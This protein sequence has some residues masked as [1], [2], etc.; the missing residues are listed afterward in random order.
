MHD[1]FKS[2]GSAVLAPNSDTQP[3]ILLIDDDDAFNSMLRDFLNVRAGITIVSVN[4]GTD[5]WKTLRES[6]FSLVIL[7]WKIPGV[8]GFT[9]FNRLRTL[10]EYEKTP[11]MVSSGL[12]QQADFRLHEEYPCTLSLAKPYS[13]KEFND[14]INRLLADRKWYANH[15]DQL[16]K[17]MDGVLQKEKSAFDE[18]Q[19]LLQKSSANTLPLSI[20][21]ARQA[22]KAKD[23]KTAE[24]LLRSVLK[25][26]PDSV[27]AMFELAKVLLENERLLEAMTLLTAAQSLSPKNL[28]RAYIMGELSLNQCQPKAAESYFDAALQIDPEHQPSQRGKSLSSALQQQPTIDLTTGKTCQS[29]AAM[30]NILGIALVRSGNYEAGIKR[31]EE[32]LDFVRNSTDQARL[33]Y[34]LGLGLT[35]AGRPHDAKKWY[36]ESLRLSGGTLVKARTALNGLA[37]DNHDFTKTEVY[38]NE[39]APIKASAKANEELMFE[40]ED[41][42][43]ADV[44]IKAEAATKAKAVA[45]AAT[46]AKAEAEAAAKAKAVAEAATKAKAE[47]EAAAKAKAKAVAEAATKAKA[48]TEAAAKAKA[49]AKP[50]AKAIAKPKFLPPPA[51]ETL[52]LPEQT[53][54]VPATIDLIKMALDELSKRQATLAKSSSPLGKAS[55][56]LYHDQDQAWTRAEK[57]LHLLGAQSTFGSY[58]IQPLLDAIRVAPY[59]MLVI[60][61]DGEAFDLIEAVQEAAYST[62]VGVLVH[63]AGDKPQLEAQ[64]KKTMFLLLDQ[65][66]LINWNRA[67]FEEQINSTLAAMQDPKSMLSQ[68][69]FFKQ[70]SSTLAP[71]KDIPVH[72]LA[73]IETA[74]KSVK[75]PELQIWFDLIKL[76]WLIRTEQPDAAKSLAAQLSK[77]AP[78]IFAV[79]LANAALAAQSG[80]PTTALELVEWLSKQGKC[81]PE[82]L[83]RIVALLIDHGQNDGA[84]TVLQIAAES[85]DFD[86]DYRY[87]FLS[88]RLLLS[89]GDAAQAAVCCEAA[90]RLYPLRW[91]LLGLYAACLQQLNDANSAIK[92]L[93]A[94][95]QCAGVNE[96]HILLRKSSYL[97]L[98]GKWSEA[99]A[100]VKLVLAKA[101]TFAEALELQVAIGK[102]QLI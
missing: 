1:V 74:R 60:W 65:M 30:I 17:I 21:A 83:E 38:E 26:K 98:S 42:P 15:Q 20:M 94:A 36:Q 66:V 10:P 18:L 96:P 89:E 28:S 78:D 90:I 47:A 49:V 53:L 91:E 19:A 87:V 84:R 54:S 70:Q 67:R 25:K 100:C 71:G 59:S 3:R 52:K 2:G 73:A 5:A 43:V 40:I 102:R 57:Q 79:R 12:L 61:N 75:A 81:T 86:K 77:K 62:R 14:S 16:V 76:A 82:R 8:A 85:T 4:N 48:V 46:K 13:E 39:N 63:S 80:Q 32:A 99:E 68:L 69:H 95:L 101:P 11:I 24:T 50:A 45:E 64:T 29:L 56:F 27:P 34:N 33:S 97:G 58:K 37:L 41:A 93:D 88:A 51:T 9:L 22:R 55:Y 31:Y 72:L 6:H 44:S 23:P 92:V 7:D 35:R